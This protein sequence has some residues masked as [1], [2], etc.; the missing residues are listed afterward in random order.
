MVKEYII[1]HTYCSILAISNCILT[2]TLYL[3]KKFVLGKKISM[4]IIYYALIQ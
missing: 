4:L 2:K 3:E 1:L